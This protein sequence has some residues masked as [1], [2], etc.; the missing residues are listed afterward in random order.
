MYERT[1]HKME[2]SSV[3]GG[4]LVLGCDYLI[5]YGINNNVPRNMHDV[6]RA[7]MS[8]SVVATNLRD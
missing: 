1:P 7:R 5:N 2:I 3:Y 6:T 8:Y 4:L